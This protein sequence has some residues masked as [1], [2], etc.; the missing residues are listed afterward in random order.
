ME[1]EKW[2]LFPSARSVRPKSCDKRENHGRSNDRSVDNVTKVQFLKFD[3]DRPISHFWASRWQK[4]LRH[5]LSSGL[6]SSL[7]H[8]VF[9]VTSFSDTEPPMSK[10]K[11]L[12]TVALQSVF[13]RDYQRRLRLLAPVTFRVILGNVIQNRSATLIVYCFARRCI[14]SSVIS[15]TRVASHQVMPNGSLTP[16]SRLP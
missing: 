12:L 15:S 4:G 7:H 16:P 1:R 11:R 3:L 10:R 13:G 2:R 14:S 6:R 9:T 8:C 5:H